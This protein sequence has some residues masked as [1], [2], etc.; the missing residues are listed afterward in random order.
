MSLSLIETGAARKL[1]PDAEA[2]KNAGL[3]LAPMR[4]FYAALAE[5][6]EALPGKRNHNERTVR[7][8][9]NQSFS[10]LLAK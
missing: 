4:K 8:V 2:H 7:A 3:S 10:S 5:Y 6:Q 9:E 1:T